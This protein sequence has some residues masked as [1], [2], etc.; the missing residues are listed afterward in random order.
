M[1]YTIIDIETTG[2]RADKERI[3]EIAIVVH[4]GTKIIETFETLIN[5]ERL[6]PPY[7]TQLT[8]INNGMVENAPRFFEVA[9]RIVELTE[10]AVFV[11]H[12]ARFD[13]SFIREEFRRLGYTFIRKQLCTVQLSRK[14]FH[15]LP[16]YS[17]ENLIKHFKIPV[18]DRHRAL[19][20]A[21]ATT[22]VF[23][24]AL[25]KVGTQE[26]IEKTVNLGVK[27]SR[28]PPNFGLEKLHALPEVCGVYYLHNKKGDVIYIGKSINIRKRLF[29]HFADHTEKAAKLQQQVFDVSFE[30]TGSE[31]VA[32]LL[33]SKEIKRLQPSINKTQRANHFPYC[34]IKIVDEEGLIRFHALKNTSVL[35]K[36]N[37]I[38]KEFTKL[39]DAKGYLRGMVRKYDLC[40]KM[41]D[42]S[43]LDGSSCF[44]YHI[45]LCKGVCCGQES[46]E[47]YNGRAEIASEHLSVGFEYDFFILDKGRSHEEKALVLIQDGTYYGYGYTDGSDEN[48]SDCIKK[49]PNNAEANRLIRQFLAGNERKIQ[50]VRV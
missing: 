34:I 10:D 20:D 19:A 33:E 1:K 45:K 3:T 30:E 43:P 27:E 29:E 39:N 13:Y 32:L 50:I 31:L 5:P 25:Q 23:E 18:K 21:L 38:L 15:G 16:S 24:K 17:L 46:V 36:K 9:K 12:N 6:I 35:R 41:M 44:N 22:E 49:Q 28:L 8:G 11:A 7:I 14:V 40:E 47:D 48:Y 37:T 2:G 26:L 4:D 42:I